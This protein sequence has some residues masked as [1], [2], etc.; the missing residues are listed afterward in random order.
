MKKYG[1]ASADVIRLKQ[2]F[3]VENSQKLDEA[4]KHASIYK[5]QPTRTVCKI[6]SAA[7]PPAK[8]FK[9]D[10]GYAICI[11]CG[12]LS[13]LHED[14]DE[15]CN[16]VYTSDNGRPYARNYYEQDRKA[17]RERV[18]LIYKPKAEFLAEALGQ[19][20]LDIK[21]LNYLDLGAG[22]GYFISALLDLG[23]KDVSGYELSRFQV[24]YANDMIGT[25]LLHC[26][27]PD[28]LAGIVSASRAEV[29][30]LV[31]VMEHLQ[32]PLKV[33][34]AIRENP[35]VKYVFFCV[36]MFSFS[37]F[38]ETVFAR[39]VMPRH[40]TG[41]HTHLFTE[42]SIK[43]LEDKFGF[44][45]VAEWWFGS[46]IMDLYRSFFVTLESQS[47]EV[48]DEFK[49]YFINEIDDLQLVLDKRHK[50]SQVHMLWRV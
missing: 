50:S 39:E 29:I 34:T 7:L 12:H 23:V 33:L 21:E 24:D 36:P 47:K 44:A 20:G 32:D 17:Y 1:K 30:S 48:A 22:S 37:V 5:S 19:Q 13:G 11:Q 25:E 10:V 49:N 46:D 2:S 9:L 3:F 8:F 15:F 40:L 45:K 31:G 35:H 42:S 16:A 18:D 4:R 28:E 41:G 27:T 38:L 26:N 43:Y 14:S 6:C